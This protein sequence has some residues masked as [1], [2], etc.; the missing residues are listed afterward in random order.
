[1]LVAPTRRHRARHQ[2][3]A[4]FKENAPSNF[5]GYTIAAA[6]RRQNQQLYGWGLIVG[7]GGL[8]QRSRAFNKDA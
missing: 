5:A 7:A 4:K 6:R 1:M 2:L 8:L 3:S